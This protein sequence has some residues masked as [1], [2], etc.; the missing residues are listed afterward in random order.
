MHE[1]RENN[2]DDMKELQNIILNIILE[3]HIEDSKKESDN[4]ESNTE[5]A[6]LNFE[7]SQCDFQS[8]VEDIVKD[9]S[10]TAHQTP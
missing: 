2:V 6:E 7:C 1:R 4:R 10:N 3:Y 9:H 5:E 8:G